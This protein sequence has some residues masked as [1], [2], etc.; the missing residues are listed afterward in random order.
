M[1]EKSVREGAMGRVLEGGRWKGMK[2]AR[3]MGRMPRGAGGEMGVLFEL[4]GK[5]AK[6]GEVCQWF[7]GV[8]AGGGVVGGGHGELPEKS[9]PL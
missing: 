8:R 6:V 3:W 5:N 2:D 7:C 9:D 4:R 1:R